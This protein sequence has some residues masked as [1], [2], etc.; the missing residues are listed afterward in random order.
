MGCAAATAKRKEKIE[1]EISYWNKRA[2]EA[3]SDA[4]L[5]AFGV[6]SGL[7]IALRIENDE[8]SDTDPKAT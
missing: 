4:W 1:H 3:N 8:R 7:R 6:A 2:S 5:V